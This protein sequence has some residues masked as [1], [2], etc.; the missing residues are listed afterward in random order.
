FQHG[1]LR[2]NNIAVLKLPQERLAYPSACSTAESTLSDN[3]DQVTHIVSSFHI[4]GFSHV[5]G[6]LWLS[7]DQAC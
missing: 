2:G 6:T 3:G 7:N 4:A 1:K 5:I